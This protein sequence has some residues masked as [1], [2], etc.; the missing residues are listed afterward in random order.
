[1]SQSSPAPEAA[2]DHS[3]VVPRDAATLVL[4]RRDQGEPQILVGKRAGGLKFMPNL[5]VFPGG[6]V[7]PADA[8]AARVSD[9]RPEV[10]AKLTLGASAQRARARDGGCA[11]SRKRACSWDSAASA[12]CA[13]SPSRGASSRLAS[14]PRFTVRLH[15]AITPPAIRASTSFLLADATHADARPVIGK[16]R[17]PRS[18][19]GRLQIRALPRR[20]MVIAEVEKRIAVRDPAQVPIPVARFTA[21]ASLEHI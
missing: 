6:R 5:Y 7:D 16:R 18:A 17:A 3:R 10:L 12:A 20:I 15:R 19:L 4:C 9:L 14:R 8:R 11:M 2:L 13:A 1:M 21:A